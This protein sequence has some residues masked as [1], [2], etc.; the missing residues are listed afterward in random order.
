MTFC[1]RVCRQIL[2]FNV[3]RFEVVG[4]GKTFPKHYPCKFSLKPSL[5]LS[6]APDLDITNSNW[7]TM[8]F[9]NTLQF[10]QSQYFFF[11]YWPV[12]G[13]KNRLGSYVQVGQ[14]TLEI[15]FWSSKLA[16][17]NSREIKTY[18]RWKHHL[19]LNLHKEQFM[20]FREWLMVSRKRI[21]NKNKYISDKS[22]LCFCKGAIF[23][24]FQPS[25]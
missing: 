23:H 13:S 20:I 22:N 16:K 9:V 18:S 7:G 15:Q 21:W 19:K 25:L 8:L 14:N 2:I 11:F 10:F 1:C 4:W 6:K 17:F 5:P 12:C 24:D 3:I